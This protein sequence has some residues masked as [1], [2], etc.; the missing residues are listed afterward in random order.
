MARGVERPTL[1]IPPKLTEPPPETGAVT[2]TVIPGLASIL[3]VTPPVAMARFPVELIGDP[4]LKYKPLEPV[5]VPVLD[6]APTEVTEPP[7][8]NDD[9]DADVI[10]PSAFTVIC[11][12]KE[13]LPYVPAGDG[14]KAA[15]PI[16]PLP[17]IGLGVKYKPLPP[18]DVLGI[19]S[20]AP[21][22]DVNVPSLMVIE[23]P[24]ET[25]EP[26]TTMPLAPF[27]VIEELARVELGMPVGRSDMVKA[28]NAGLPGELLEGPAKTVLAFSFARV[29]PKV[30][31]EVIGDPV[32]L[33]IKGTVIA[34]DETLGFPELLRYSHWLPE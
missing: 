17:V 25:G 16:E 2:F 31:A 14:L 15:S 4:E 10:C 22:I 26:L 21:L 1:V 28:L 13:I 7:P 9:E 34:T 29:T 32:I 3:L 23:P 24:R 19:D 33:N 18:T 11:G 6:E 5:C 8:G 27:T 30:P 12:I 20:V